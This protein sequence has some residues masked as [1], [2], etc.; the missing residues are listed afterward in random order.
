MGKREIIVKFVR[1]ITSTAMTLRE[2]E[3]QY[4]SLTP[5]G[6]ND[7]IRSIRAADND[8]EINSL[9]LM[10]RLERFV[11]EFRPEGRRICGTGED[12]TSGD[13]DT[14]TLHGRIVAALL[15]VLH[16]TRSASGL[17]SYTLLFLEYASAVVRTKYDYLTTALDVICY[18]ITSPGIDWHAVQNAT[19]LDLLSYK[20][21]DGIRFDRSVS[22]VF[23]FRGK[24]LVRCEGGLLS[25][26]SSDAVQSGARAFS[27]CGD[28]I[29]V[30][31]R[32]VR[33]EK[34]RSSDQYTASALAA[35]ADTFLRVQEEGAKKGTAKREY[36]SGEAVDIQITSYSTLAC[37]IVDDKI[38]VKG[39][40][41][42]EE[43]IKGLWTRDLIPYLYDQ[44]CIRGAVL[45]MDPGGNSFSIRDAYAAYAK[46]TANREF[47]DNVCFQAKVY[48][49]NGQ[50]GRVSWITPSGYAGL[51][52][53]EDF[54]GVKEGDVETLQ[55]LNIQTNGTNTYINLCRPRYGVNELRPFPE[56]DDTLGG[57]VT[58]REKVLS[59]REV[60][61]EQPSDRGRDTL[62]V[63]STILSSTTAR[64]SSMDAYRH[65]LV[66]LFLSEVRDD[67]EAVERLRAQACY[68]GQRLCFAQEGTLLPT[69][70]PSLPEKAEAVVR[71]LSGWKHPEDA[72]CEGFLAGEGQ[73]V[74]G[75]VARLIYSLKI[76]SEFQ[77]EVRVDRETVRKKICGILG[78]ADS[79]ETGGGLRR[80]KYG[81]AEGHEVEFKSSYVFRNDGK[82]ADLDYQGRGQVFEAVCGFLNADGGVLYL[83]VNDAGEPLVAKDYGLSA[84]M[85][86]L[87]ENYLRV[88]EKRLRALG[89][90]VPKA[91]NLDHYVLF[92]NA[93]KELYFKETLLGN[94]TIE[95]TEDGDAIRITVT[96]AEYE[97][98]YLYSDRTRSDGVAYVRDGGRT[99]P[100]SRVQKEQR[101]SSLKR[102]SREMGF[103][104]TI[105]EAIDRRRRLI[106]KDYA[107]GNS[108]EVKDRYVVPINLF[109]NDENVYCFDLGSKKY[110]QF[111]LHRIGAI[112]YSEDASPYPLPVTGPMRADVF[113]WLMPEGERTYHV[114][115]RMDVG[116]KNYLLEEY[117]CAEK[118][119]KEEFYEE[120]KNKWILDTRVSGLGA[121]RRFYLGLADKIEILDTE[122]SEELKKEIAGFLGRFINGDQS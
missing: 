14:L 21:L 59:G 41:L 5:S 63:L 43:L 18:K 89:H 52:R 120:K 29:E 96:P 83:G 116:A 76:A 32:N 110:K 9:S 66:A 45:N 107:S 88:N 7:F 40:I 71:L 79:Y 108:G 115:L 24:G 37:E 38:E 22:D 84:D 94:I 64:G 121:V 19:S 28:R 80:G 44:D 103:V 119:P 33:E 47:R 101:L 26:S 78:V 16:K 118:L 95:V 54:P 25:V 53:L 112:E 93:E 30:Y 97:I 99:L 11:T 3:S 2:L 62:E 113:R 48:E 8:P 20:L 98:A 10:G 90:P 105:Q 46:E 72:A 61:R 91:D 50:W 49:V 122:D 1:L 56:D 36:G 60:T 69:R 114:R 15:L 70:T 65:L 12:M 57:F 68:L 111:R 74:A 23:S 39:T 100:M 87:C 42:D 109:Y 67:G 75:E 27:V 82:G 55:V 102:I 35:F 34:M 17:R 92:L 86:W 77:D 85:T 4:A 106:F 58:T 6:G 13:R 51:T 81:A 31:T 117:S 104:V 73:S